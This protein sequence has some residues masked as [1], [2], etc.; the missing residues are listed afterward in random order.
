[1]WMHGYVLAMSVGYFVLMPVL[2]YELLDSGGLE[3]AFVAFL[4]NLRAVAQDLAMIPAALALKRITARKALVL[5]CVM[6]GM[7]FL[8]FGAGDR[9]VLVS[10]AVFTGMGGGL[11][12]PA[13]MRMYV[14]L[15]HP[16]ERA[17]AFARREMLN[18]LGAVIGPLLCALLLPGGL[19]TL[20]LAS[21]IL[22]MGCALASLHTLPS[23]PPWESPVQK[24]AT[25]AV[26]RPYA[27]FMT[28][29]ALAAVLQ[30]QQTVV[31]AVCAK[32]MGYAGVQWVTLAVYAFLALIQMPLSGWTA[33]RLSV[34]VTLA[35]SVLLFVIGLAVQWFLPALGWLY[36]GNLVF[37]CGIALFVPAKNQAF[38]SMQQ[39]MDAAMSVGV[40]GLM[41]SVASASVGSVFVLAYDER[42][43]S[44]LPLLLGGGVALSAA[45]ARSVAPR[46]APAKQ[47]PK[48]SG[49]EGKS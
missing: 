22:Y 30:N 4:G 2:S 46:C 40:H 41:T 26:W 13:A 36:L 11:F 38:A 15:T 47:L 49:S 12:F 32:K 16:S 5:A 3:A 23:C 18:S 45:L 29:C 9:A 33:A 20:C 48:E 28:S 44:L 6:R 17:S 24:T 34:P 19:R 37:A 42:H 14:D 7:G 21:G 27:G 35:L 31:L 43:E 10:A 8:L 25:L 39:Q 1:M